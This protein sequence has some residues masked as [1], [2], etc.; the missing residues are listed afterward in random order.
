MFKVYENRVGSLDRKYSIG[1]IQMGKLY[2]QNENNSYSPHLGLL[3]DSIHNAGLKTAAFGNS[4]TDEEEIRTSA[5]IPM[6]SRGLVD[7]GN[8]DDILVDDGNYPYGFKTDYEKAI[9][10]VLDIRQK[11]SLI[12]IDTGDLNRLNSFSGFLS[13][14]VFEQKRNLILQDID[15]F[16]GNLAGNINKEKSLLIVLSP[17]SGEERVAGN[18]LAPIIL[19][20]KGVEKGTITSSTTNRKGIVSNLDIA[21]MAASFLGISTNNMLGNP[22]KN[23]EAD[24]AFNY[25]NSINGC[26]NTTSKVRSKT[27]LIYGIISIII[28]LIIIMLYVLNIRID[29]RIGEFFSALLLLLYG[30]PMI[31]I[32]SFLFNIDNILKFMVSLII[33]TI[34]FILVI[35]KYNKQN[36]IYFLSFSYFI[37]ILIDSLFNGIITRFSVLSHDPIIGARYFGLG[38]E[39]VG[40]FLAA[41]TLSAGLLYRKY[42]KRFIPI[43]ILLLAVIIGG[44]PRL[45]ANVGGTISLLIAALYF[46]FGTKERK[47]NLKSIILIMVLTVSVIM[48]LGYIDTNF[49]PNPTHLGKTLNSLNEKGIG[50]VQNIINRK[51]LMNIKLVG[52]S[53]WTKVLFVNIFAQAIISCIYIE[54]IEDIMNNNLGKGISSGIVGSII[55]FLV[56]D[57]GI[58]LSAISMNLITIFLLF[59]II[60]DEEICIKRETD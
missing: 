26:I 6:D 2:N 58:I 37:I 28:M 57:S 32:L 16:I 10:E 55:G 38:N 46:I 24:E 31:F 45:G 20:G 43:F 11:A 35:K 36:I 22:I 34:V 33:V 3:G 42:N 54:K 23:M 29:N 19:W 8:L 15:G 4:D 53:I 30:G 1:N 49:N 39:M 14:D 21:P 50:I 52:I 51:L 5:L 59:M 27:L 48:V 44:Y 41:T 18:K 56:N 25:A 9:R 47:L 40:V 13:T 60:D 12:L 7:Y 17:N